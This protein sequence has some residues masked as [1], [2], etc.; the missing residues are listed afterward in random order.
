MAEKRFRYTLDHEDGSAEGI[1]EY[2][3]GDEA[4]VEKC[5]RRRLAA[6][7][8]EEQE[9][10]KILIFENEDAAARGAKPVGTV[11]LTSQ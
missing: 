8:F 1:H 4:T 11:T 10:G 3:D 6:A 7:Y 2:G 9:D 5:V